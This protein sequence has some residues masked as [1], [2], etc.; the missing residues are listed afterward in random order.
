MTKVPQAGKV[1]TRLQPFL[2]A[3]Q[4]AEIAICFLQDTEQKATSVT[5]NL[6]VA[7]SPIEKKNLLI[8]ILQTNPILVEQKG[9][10]LGERMFHAFEFAF[11]RDSDAVVMIGTDSPTFPSEFIER[12]FITLETESDA[13]LGKTEDGGFYLIGLRSL[14]KKIFEN[15]EW[16]SPRT[17]EQTRQNIENLNLSL[18]EISAWYDVDTPKDLMKLEKELA[19]KRELA[20]KTFEFLE[21]LKQFSNTNT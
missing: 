2:S 6:I 12:A 4:S 14:D 3:Q 10:N 16:S 19:G 17:F 7:F 20:L 15:I 5:Q 1:K 21:G 8:E 9:D 13:V 11:S 18:S